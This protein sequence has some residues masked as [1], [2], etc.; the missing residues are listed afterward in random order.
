VA[1]ALQFDQATKHYGTQ[2]ALD[3]LTLSV[4]PGEIV[5]FLGPN[6]AG[7]STA[8]YLAMGFLRLSAGRGTI[9]GK[10]FGDAETRARVG[11]LPDSP[12]FFSGTARHAIRLAGALSG[13]RDPKL[14]MRTDEMLRALNLD[15]PRKDVRKFSRGMQQRAALAAALVQEPDV[16]ILDEPTSALDPT[17]VIEVRELLREARDAGKA[18]FFSSH[19]LSEVEE[20]C[21]RVAFLRSGK[22]ERVGTLD[23]LTAVG[24]QVEIVARVTGEVPGFHAERLSDRR[25][26]FLVSPS[27]ERKCIESIWAHRGELLSVTRQRRSLEELFIESQGAA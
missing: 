25:V 26:R 6:G 13:M 20:V 11:F 18:V 24:A 7:K 21:D 4:E 3:A 19:Q 9:L 12:A 15:E 1:P 22:L 10:P 14:R 27:E 5:G 23:Q 16:L 2:T 17:G 8:I